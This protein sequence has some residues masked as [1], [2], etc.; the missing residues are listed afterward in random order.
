VI[1][2]LG[3][4]NTVQQWCFSF[5]H[6]ACAKCVGFDQRPRPLHPNG[7]LYPLGNGRYISAPV[8]RDVSPG[9]VGFEMYLRGSLTPVKDPHAR[10]KPLAF[11]S[12]HG[13]YITATPERTLVSCVRW[14][15]A[16]TYSRYKL[17]T[18]SLPKRFHNGPFQFWNRIQKWLKKTVGNPRKLWIWPGWP[19]WTKKIQSKQP[20][21]SS[22]PS[23]SVPDTG[24]NGLLN[25][26]P[27]EVRF[28]CF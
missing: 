27:S 23:N 19:Y 9:T 3:C 24:K 16:V 18:A 11:T 6:S 4:A 15:M 10:I 7:H 22:S 17:V 28:L 26:L 13:R 1:L 5:R 12:G 20:R 8:I 21:P 25:R 2:N 14:G